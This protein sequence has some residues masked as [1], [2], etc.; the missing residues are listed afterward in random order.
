MA[1]AQDSAQRAAQRAGQEKIASRSGPF[2]RFGITYQETC[3]VCHGEQLQG[4]AQGTQLRGELMH[5][6]SVIELARN[7]GTGFPDQG[8]PAWSEVFTP[9]VSSLVFY[10][11][12][13][14]PEWRD[15]IIVGSLKA[16]NLYRIE[17]ENN[18]F[19]RKETLISNLTRIRDVELGP[20]GIIYLLLEHSTGGQIVR[21][22][23]STSDDDGEV[24]QH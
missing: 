1:L 8:M 15:D 18:E 21:V 23:Q 12:D 3:A 16:A 10:E 22:V 13:A 17:I 11:G 9:A 6:D 5:G 7:I 19:V 4:A 24:A 2:S 20:G 14:F